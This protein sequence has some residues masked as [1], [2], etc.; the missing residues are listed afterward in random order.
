[1]APTR[2]SGQEFFEISRVGLGLI[3]SGRFGSALVGFFKSHGSGPITV[4][5]T[6]PTR[7]Q[8]SPAMI[9]RYIFLTLERW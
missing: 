1:M 3:G 9:F 8:P 4:T 7:E 2:G 6:D 5:R